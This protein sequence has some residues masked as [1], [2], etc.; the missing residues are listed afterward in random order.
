[1]PVGGELRADWPQWRG[2]DRNGYLISGEALPEKLPEELTSLWRVPAGEG[3]SSPVVAGGRLVAFDNQGG[4]ETLRVLDAATGNELWRQAVDAVFR[5]NQGPPGP[6][7]TPVIDAER[8]Y[9]QSCKG[10]FQ[11]RDVA[12]GDLL[13]RFHFQ[14]YGATFIGERG[15]APGAIRHGNTGAPVIHGNHIVVP[16]GS[17]NNAGLVCFEKRTGQMIWRSGQDLAAYAAPMV[18]EVGSKKQL[19]HFDAA[20]LA[21]FDFVEG[22]QLWR[23]PV[24]TAYSRHVTTPILFENTIVAASHQYGLFC[25]APAVSE[26]FTDIQSV[27]EVWRTSEGAMNF[28]SPILLDEVIYGLG[29]NRNI[30]AVDVRNGNLLWEETDW[31]TTSAD[32]AHATHVTDG[33]RILT[34]ADSGELFLW[35]PSRQG[36]GLISRAQGV[37]MNWC[38]LA[39]SGGVV[40]LRDGI[41]G[42]GMWT[43]LR[44]KADDL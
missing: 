31:I 6:R 10:E 33:E 32:K 44:L 43:A 39:Y 28:S 8:L 26:E 1:M 40:Y 17:T 11:C 15:T 30:V 21:G 24:T 42:T 37:G 13:W 18:G 9:V 19:I 34:L 35:K 5:D 4:Q 14:D 7:A 3:F 29:P 41:Q 27:R 20:G 12:T 36:P 25:V 38:H 23:F 22:Q 16:V 2:P